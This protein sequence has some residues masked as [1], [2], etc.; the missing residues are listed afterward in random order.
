MVLEDEDDDSVIRR[1]SENSSRPRVVVDDAVVVIA[2]D[3]LQSM[4]AKV[5]EAQ[6]VCSYCYFGRETVTLL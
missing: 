1:G 5:F 3:E 4:Y 2:N 6:T